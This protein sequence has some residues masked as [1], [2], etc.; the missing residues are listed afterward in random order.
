MEKLAK[1]VIAI[2]FTQDMAYV[3]LARA[4]EELGYHKAALKYYQ[5][6]YDLYKDGTP[7]HHCRSFDQMCGGN[8]MAKY[9][10]KMIKQTEDY[11]ENNKQFGPFLFS[12]ESVNAKR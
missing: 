9:L 7:M 6:A 1:A 5:T 12:V 2:G 4:A 3:F 8:D 11:L 10:P